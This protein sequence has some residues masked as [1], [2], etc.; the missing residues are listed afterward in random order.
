MN[1]DDQVKSTSF[2]IEPSF[3]FCWSLAWR[4]ILLS[5]GIGILPLA[6]VNIC[7]SVAGAALPDFLS[8]ALLIIGNWLTVVTAFSIALNILL[9]KNFKKTYVRFYNENV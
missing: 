5:M 3:Q 4:L 2:K 7:L 1:K 8:T 9:S 6:T